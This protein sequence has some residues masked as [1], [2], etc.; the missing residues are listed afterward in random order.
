MNVYYDIRKENNNY[1]YLTVRNNIETLVVKVTKYTILKELLEYLKIDI[2]DIKIS[3]N[4]SLI[5]IPIDIQ[6]VLTEKTELIILN[7]K[8]EI[9]SKKNMDNCSNCGLCYTMC[10]W[11]INPLKT[12]KCCNCGLC[13]YVCPSKRK[14]RVGDSSG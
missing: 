14:L 4:N 8:E 2:T 3:L 7:K 12:S 10:P 13:N 5:N 9:E 11:H 1:I 6:Y